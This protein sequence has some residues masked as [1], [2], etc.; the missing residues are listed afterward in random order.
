MVLIILL[1]LFIMLKAFSK[2]LIFM[3]CQCH[4]LRNTSYHLFTTILQQTFQ[5]IGTVY[6]RKQED[7]AWRKQLVVQSSKGYCAFVSSY[8]GPIW[9]EASRYFKPPVDP[10]KCP[11]PKVKLTFV[12]VI[13]LIV[14]IIS[15]FIK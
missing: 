1:V 10:K 12:Y 14:R 15:I 3:P 4:C 5:A 6:I 2:S 7:E 11:Y 8:L 13:K 9:V